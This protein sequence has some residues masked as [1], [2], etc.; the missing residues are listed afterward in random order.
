MKEN[1]FVK[2]FALQF[3]ETDPESI[4]LSTN[5][6]DLEEWSSLVALSVMAMVDEEYGVRITADDFKNSSTLADVFETIK[7]RL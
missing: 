7:K 3:D 4:S 2:N 5:F 6:K 1:D